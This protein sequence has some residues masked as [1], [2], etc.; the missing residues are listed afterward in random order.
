MCPAEKAAALS[1]A[2]IGGV[3][4]TWY[5]ARPPS[6]FASSQEASYSELTNLWLSELLDCIYLFFILQNLA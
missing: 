1:A 6:G 2:S 5:T 4:T 3:A